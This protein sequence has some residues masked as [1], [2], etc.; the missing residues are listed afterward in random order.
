MYG[1]KPDVDLRFFIGKTLE[2]VAV[3]SYDVQFH[4]HGSVS[5][6]VQNQI[7]HVVLASGGAPRCKPD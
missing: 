2:Q 6:S 1:L 7:A 5:L 3:G 4:F